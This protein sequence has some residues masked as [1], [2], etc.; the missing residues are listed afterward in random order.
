MKSHCLGCGLPVDVQS[1]GGKLLLVEHRDGERPSCPA[2]PLLL[3]HEL[4]RDFWLEYY[5]TPAAKLAD[6]PVAAVH[7]RLQD[8]EAFPEWP[9]PARNVHRWFVLADG[10]AV[11]FNENPSRGWS[12]PVLRYSPRT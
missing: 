2:V 12:Y 7:S 3:R 4:G 1:V 6:V 11:G 8:D 9:G 5:D 10:H